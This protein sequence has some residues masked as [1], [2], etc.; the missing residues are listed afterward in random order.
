MVLAEAAAAK[1][2]G[3]VVHSGRLTA[4]ETLAKGQSPGRTMPFYA[5]AG[6][7]FPAG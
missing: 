7:L 1:G 2:G 6:T 5:Y 3:D 4:R